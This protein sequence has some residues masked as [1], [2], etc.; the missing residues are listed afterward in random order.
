MVVGI[1]IA[2]QL[3]FI[4][5]SVTGAKDFV[6]ILSRLILSEI[7]PLITSVVLVGRSCTGIVVDLGNTKVAGELEPLHYS[8]INIDDY[9]VLPRIVCMVISQVI[10]ALYFSAIMLMF[11]VIFSLLIYEISAQESLTELLNLVTTDSLFGFMLK[12]VCFGLIIGTVACFHGLLVNNA[13]IHV[14]EQ[15]QKAVVRCIVFLF[16]VDSYFIVFTL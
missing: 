8:G 16:L 5:V 7:G 14:S 11:G 6:E 15:M 13:S 9:V 10:L 1:S 4:I 12:N 3:V 2:S